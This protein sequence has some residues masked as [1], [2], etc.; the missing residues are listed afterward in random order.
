[1]IYAIPSSG[2]HTS[3][4]RRVCMQRKYKAQVG[5]SMI[6]HEKALHNCFMPCHRKYIALHNQCGA[7][8]EASVDYR[9]IYNSFHPF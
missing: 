2:I 5:Y 4:Y 7:R 8:W 3:F 6:N 9:R 1:M